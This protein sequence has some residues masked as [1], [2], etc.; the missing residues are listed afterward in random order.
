MQQQRYAFHCEANTAF[1]IIS[2][3]FS[4]RQICNLN[5]IPFRREK[6]QAF[7]IRKNSSFHD[8]FA[9]KIFWMRETG[10]ISK[11]QRHWN[12]Q[13]PPCL[14]NALFSSIE[15]SSTVASIELLIFGY[16]LTIVI[17]LFEIVWHRRMH[18]VIL[19]FKRSVLLFDV[20]KETTF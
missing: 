3:T 8:I 20:E 12:A 18:R 17:L 1:P 11:H 2:D 15:I 7:V 9:I 14:S 4:P 6:M 13:Q 5:V 16:S 19:M 10:I